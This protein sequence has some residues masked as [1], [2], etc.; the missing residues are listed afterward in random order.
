MKDTARAAREGSRASALLAV[1]GQ[2]RR[3]KGWRHLGLRERVRLEYCLVPAGCRLS[4]AL[5]MALDLGHTVE[6]MQA[7]DGA[8]TLGIRLLLPP[9]P[10]Q[11]RSS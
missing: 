11:G 3:A 4:D 10:D 7:R 5:T 2:F 9:A 8:A 1:E 6:A